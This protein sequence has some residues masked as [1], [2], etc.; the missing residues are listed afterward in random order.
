MAELSKLSTEELMRL[1][2]QPS[3]DLSTL[4]NE[5]LMALKPEK[6]SALVRLGRGFADVAQGVKQGALT[7]KDLFTGG[8]EA[9]DYT[10]AKDEEL[11]N[12]ER[13]RGPDAGIDWTRLGGNVLATVPAMLIPGANAAGLGARVASGAAQGATAAG[14]MYTPEGQSKLGQIALGGVVGGAVP[15]LVQGVK[16]GAGAVMDKLRPQVTVPAQGALAG[17]ISFKLQQQGVDWNALTAEVKNSL[18]ADAE[19]SLSSGGSLDQAMLGN[20]ALIESVGATPTRASLTRA[21]RDWQA[22][23]N[24]RGIV[25]VGDG[26]VAREQSNAAAL[27]DY[28]GKLRSATDGTASTALEAGESS[29]KAIKALD[30]EKEKVVSK[31]YDAFRSSGAQDA[32]VPD[33]RIAD[34]LGRVADE[35]GVENIPAA[36]QSRLKS[37]GFID[38]ERT[39]LLTVNEADKLNRLINNNNPGFGPQSLALGRLK[40][41]LN[42][43]L[44][45][46][47]AGG[48]EGLL[49][50]RKAAAQRFAEQR[51]GK[52]IAAA[53]DDVS[54][55]RF[56]KRFVL[57]ADVRDVRAL[58]DELLKSPGGVQAINDT[59]GHILDNLLMKATGAT[60]VED[61]VGKPFSGVRFGKALDA[62][63]PEKLH[64]LFSPSEVESL[65]TLQKASK[66]LT[67]EVPFSDVN[68]SKTT[69]ALANILQKIGN[70]PLIGKMVSPIIGTGKIGMDWVKNAGQRK[71]V[72]EILLGSAG[73]AGPGMP[74][75]PA[76][77][78][79]R[80]LPGGAAAILTP[81]S[82]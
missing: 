48:S 26:I 57:D 75:A 74:L 20:K 46:V 17:E 77:N 56:V 9:K 72:A 37:F 7:V 42:E 79:E 22:E 15:A 34:T 38:G 45:E 16:S 66:L 36:V 4:S 8:Q 41:A 58:R 50:A 39:K 73:K 33:T 80:L 82:E 3:V 60:N 63:A 32:A 51:A 1:K 10:K 21:P 6:P 11:A 49:T 28:L 31:L 14:M 54:P 69:A 13:G 47:E 18:L 78:L 12:Y 53:I 81:V 67:E 61:V 65:R 64:T 30:A 40:Q 43:S 52:G 62:I 29:I 68:H 2:S 76:G 5:E 24:M 23:K 55:D 19:K 27:T 35:I 44:L 59:K 71:E 70:T 25:G